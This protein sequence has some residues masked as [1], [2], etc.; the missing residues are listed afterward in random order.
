LLRV[1]AYREYSQARALC[2]SLQFQRPHQSWPPQR[3]AKQAQAARVQFRGRGLSAG[4]WGRQHGPLQWRN[5][6]A[7][8][9]VFEDAFY[10]ATGR[11]LWNATNIYAPTLAITGQ[12][13]T[14]SDPEDR[15]VLMRDIVHAPVK[16]TALIPDATHFVLFEKNR[17]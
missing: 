15:E 17:F 13:D 7:P 10:Q 6:T 3:P 16:Q 5:S 12:Y 4:P 9:G 2:A 1:I 14:W 11:P 8:N